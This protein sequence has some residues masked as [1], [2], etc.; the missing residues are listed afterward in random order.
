MSLGSREDFNLTLL[1]E[2][3]LNGKA[4]LGVQVASPRHRQVK[5]L[6]DSN[7]HLLVGMEQT[8]PVATGKE[9]LQRTIYNEFKNFDGLTLATKI[10][11]FRDGSKYAEAMLLDASF[12]QEHD[13]SLFAKP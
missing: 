1:G 13:K 5:L 9:P 6:F 11:V 8:I 3:R 7:T 12:G 2:E 10:A 4:V